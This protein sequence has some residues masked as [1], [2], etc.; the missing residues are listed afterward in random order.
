MAEDLAAWSHAY[1]PGKA[2]LALAE[3]SLRSAPGRMIAV[4][5]HQLRP[6]FE[7][8][9]AGGRWGAQARVLDFDDRHSRGRGAFSVVSLGTVTAQADGCARQPRVGNKHEDPRS[10][11]GLDF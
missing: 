5:E 11:G 9:G 7:R 4:G 8:L 1:E 3:R 2:D 6:L 10:L